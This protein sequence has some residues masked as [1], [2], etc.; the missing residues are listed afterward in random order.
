MKKIIWNIFIGVFLLLNL[1]MLATSTDAQTYNPLSFD[2][3][4][5]PLPTASH[6]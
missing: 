4:T 6:F 5:T 3:G 1:I 2:V